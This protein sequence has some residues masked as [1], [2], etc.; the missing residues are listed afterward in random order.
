MRVDRVQTKFVRVN[1]SKIPGTTCTTGAT[2]CIKLFYV[3][4]TLADFFVE[5]R[6]STFYNSSRRKCCTFVLQKYNLWGDP[7]LII[8]VPF[9]V[10]IAY[11]TGWLLLWI[12]LKVSPELV[13]K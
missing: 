8:M 1:G 7:L 9:V 11:L 12:A 13:Q 2:A 3:F 10:A 4:D 5:M 6:H